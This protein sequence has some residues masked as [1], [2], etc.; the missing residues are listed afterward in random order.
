M[1]EPKGRSGATIPSEYFRALYRTT[2]DPWGFATSP[3][4]REKYA[5]TV[6]ALPRGRYLRALELG[7]SVGVFTRMLAARCDALLAVDVSPDALASAVAR[8]VDL[9]QVRF[10]VCDLAVEFPPGAYDLIT[11][12]ELGFYFAPS[13]LARIVNDLA[14]ALQPHG[15]C[16]LVH[17]T[18]LVDGHAQTA[19]DVHEAFLRDRRFVHRAGSR[20]P[21]YR[22][23][24]FSRT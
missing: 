3:Y 4:D 1:A 22:L 8:C 17:W 20:A 18:P 19:D 5:E 24:V 21:T 2:A 23:D 12:C 16:I 14:G 6:R 10:A 9:P 11:F 13:D 7:C 15:D